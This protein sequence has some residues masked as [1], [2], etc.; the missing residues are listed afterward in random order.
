MKVN[1]KVKVNMNRN[2]KYTCKSKCKGEKEMTFDF[3]YSG[4]FAHFLKVNR[5]M[6]I[7]CCHILICV[8]V[9]YKVIIQILS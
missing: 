7:F 3:M 2:S 8:H 4:T 5:C 9:L 6:S 1:A